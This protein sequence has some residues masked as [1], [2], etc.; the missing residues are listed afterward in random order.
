MD[1]VRWWA[2]PAVERRRNEWQVTPGDR[3]YRPMYAYSGG[4]VEPVDV[5]GSRV[6][7]TVGRY[8]SAVQRYLHTGDVSAL[9][10]F[11]G[12]KVGGVELETDL[13]VID[14]MARRGQFDFESIY[15]VVAA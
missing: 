12:T 5:R 7:S 15:R 8:H 11:A 1:A 13:D 3:L 14:E 2:S 4:R 9:A 10:R 6:A